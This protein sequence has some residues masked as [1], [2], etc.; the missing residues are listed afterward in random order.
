MDEA[1]AILPKRVL[2][3]LDNLPAQ[4]P[5][6]PHRFWR[7]IMHNRYS[8]LAAAAFLICLV[9]SVLL[10]GNRSAWAEML[11]ALDKVKYVHLVEI[12]TDAQGNVSRRKELWVRIHA[13]MRQETGNLVK[14]DN[15]REQL[16]LFRKERTAQLADSRIAEKPMETRDFM[17]MFDLFNAPEITTAPSPEED[18]EEAEAFR[19]HGKN[20]PQ[21]GIVTAW[22]HKKSRLP[23]RITY[24]PESGPVEEI[25]FNY[26]P[27]PD[28]MFS[29]RIP[30]GYQELP[31]EQRGNISGKVLDETGQ[32]VPYAEVSVLVGDWGGGGLAGKTNGGGAFNISLPISGTNSIKFPVMLLAFKKDVPDRVAWTV[33]PR[34][35]DQN[36]L[37]KDVPG[38]VGHVTDADRVGP[39]MNTAGFLTEASDII[40]TLEPAGRIR[41]I[42]RDAKGQPIPGA[43]ITVGYNMLDND[44]GWATHF[45]L[46]TSPG[47]GLPLMYTGRQGQY[48]ISNLP[49]YKKE[50]HF[51][52]CV[53][54]R[55]YVAERDNVRSTAP[56]FDEEIN[57]LL[58]DSSVTVSGQVR[59]NA[60]KPLSGYEVFPVVEERQYYTVKAVTDDEGRF[61]LSGCPATPDLQL[62]FVGNR[63]PRP[64]RVNPSTGRMI[65]KSGFTYYPCVDMA[66]PYE[67][68]KLEYDVDI[69]V[70]KPDLTY[71]VTVR[72]AAGEPVP[73]WPL[74][75]RSHPSDAIPGDWQDHDFR[76]RTDE[77]GQCV[78]TGVPRL[79]GLVLFGWQGMN[80]PGDKP[81]T[82][83]EAAIRE[84]NRQYRMAKT[85]PLQWEPGKKEYE[86]EIALSPAKRK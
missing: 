3:R 14:I 84:R 11:S 46:S 55:G 69:V 43:L 59:D 37:W 6:Q 42:V 86:V 71:V 40:L 5:V 19:L 34:P 54:R 31:R 7:G 29:T 77:R 4:S 78:F 27:I 26:D 41:G 30:E 60:G 12:R 58:Y 1:A 65:E 49:I 61:K 76:K 52:L 28:E 50:A 45:A 20:T 39:F 47:I 68:G 21:T 16:T 67:P 56:S 24:R 25:A 38:R 64:P 73:Q 10:L 80:I 2:A 51:Q 17:L 63:D 81:P 44:R 74:E 36:E 85:L 82:P 32:P 35:G 18:T 8:Q 13:A 70:Q 9:G 53:A 48:E 72:N 62:R 75:L 23:V 15:G 22:I 57:F 33:I 66:I 79:E 83:E